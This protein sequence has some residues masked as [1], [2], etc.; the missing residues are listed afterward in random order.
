MRA[1]PKA[2][3]F[4]LAEEGHASVWKQLM[5]CIISIRTRDEATLPIARRLFARAPSPADLLAVPHDELV[6]LLAGTSYPEAKAPRMIAIARAAVD[7]FNGTLPDDAEVLM[8][9]SGVGPKCAHVTLGVAYGRPLIS[10]DVHVHRVANRWGCVSTSAP[11]RTLVELEKRVASERWIDVNRLIMP[12][13]KFICT[14]PV[15]KCLSCP[16]SDMCPKIGVTGATRESAS[17]KSA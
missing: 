8:S 14:A 5:A 1:Y 16:L 13:G 7:R 11:E 9:F 10:V 4:Q 12:F 17:P 15:P 2:A 3:L 6:R